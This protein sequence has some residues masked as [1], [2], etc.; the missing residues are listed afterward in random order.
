MKC[1]LHAHHAAGEPKRS[2]RH[3]MS[4]DHQLSS[5]SFNSP[6]YSGIHKTSRSY[7]FKNSSISSGVIYLSLKRKA[8]QPCPRGPY[9]VSSRQLFSR[10][11]KCHL[12]LIFRQ[13]E[14]FLYFLVTEHFDHPDT[15]CGPP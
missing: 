3:G 11:V 12:H 6:G 7:G 2:D 5:Y 9:P 13:L 10:T 14:R 1:S 4:T 15:H 8:Q